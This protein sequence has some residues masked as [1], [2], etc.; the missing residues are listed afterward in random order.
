MK[1]EILTNS[2][3]YCPANVDLIL[4]ITSGSVRN[5]SSTPGLDSS[6][7]TFFVPAKCQ[8]I[9]GQTAANDCSAINLKCHSCELKFN[10]RRVK[11]I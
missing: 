10:I 11:K 7:C 4:L 2:R 9:E 5:L 3:E 6:C 1:F 8:L